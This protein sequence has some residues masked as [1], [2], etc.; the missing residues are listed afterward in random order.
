MTG[1]TVYQVI[2]LLNEAALADPVA[3]RNLVNARVACNQALADHPTIQ[4]GHIDDD[5]LK[6]FQVGVLGLL[7]GLFGVDDQGWG[8]IAAIIDDDPAKLIT[9]THA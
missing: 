3:M 6:P 9:F 7:N 5:P 2:A 8:A 1:I 4:V